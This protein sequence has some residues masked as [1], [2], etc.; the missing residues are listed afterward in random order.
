M[1]IWEEKMRYDFDEHI[2]PR[3]KEVIKCPKCREIQVAIVLHTEPEPTRYH[4]CKG[5]GYEIMEDEWEKLK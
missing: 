4:C 3:S 1:E 2:P 5:C